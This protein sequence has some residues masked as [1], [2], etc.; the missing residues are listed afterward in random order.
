[1]EDKTTAPGYQPPEA[2]GKTGPSAEDFYSR[3][4]MVLGNEA[5]NKLK[6]AKVII[7]G[8]GGV[9]GFALEALVRAG[10]GSITA[11]D[12]DTVAPSNLN[13]QIIATVDTI[14]RKKVDVAKERA[15][16]INPCIDFEA[17]PCFYSDE[18]KGEF[19]L[20]AYDYVIDAIDY[21]PGKIALVEAAKSCGTPIISAMGAG[22]KLDP[23]RFRVADISKTYGDPLARAV[24]T[25]LKKLGITSLKVVFS[26]EEPTLSAGERVPGS[27]SFV[28]SVAGLI[29]GGEVIKDIAK[30]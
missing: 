21:V 18:T 3:T 26:D 22:N 15:Q 5:I 20:S 1:M 8:V 7:F 6:K 12:S 17:I 16:S 14:G 19:D 30:Q 29:I 27:L 2:S 23:T 28:P 4:G 13:R 9:G 10:V 25:R 24:R 11:V